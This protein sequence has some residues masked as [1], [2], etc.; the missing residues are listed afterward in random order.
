[1]MLAVKLIK[2]S[3]TNKFKTYKKLVAGELGFS[4]LILI[5]K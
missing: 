2:T 1:M 5:M 3:R 4:V